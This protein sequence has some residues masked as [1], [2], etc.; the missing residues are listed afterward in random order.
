MK[1]KTAH[2]VQRMKSVIFSNYNVCDVTLS[3]HPHRASWKVCLT[4][5]VIFTWLQYI[6]YCTLT[7]THT[8][9]IIFKLVWKSVSVIKAWTLL[10]VQYVNVIYCRLENV[11]LLVS[12]AVA[13]ILLSQKVA[14]ILVGDPHQQIYGFRGATNAMDQV[15]STHIY[16]LTQVYMYWWLQSRLCYSALSHTAEFKPAGQRHGFTYVYV[17]FLQYSISLG[18]MYM[19]GASIRGGADSWRFTDH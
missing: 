3:V 12:V 11:F 13:D 15:D 2:Q 1:P 6:Q 9:I 19:M 14:K 4:T 16:Y 8:E 7:P 5:V 17:G 10:Y 18:Y